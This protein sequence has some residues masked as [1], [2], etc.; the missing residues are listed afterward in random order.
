MSKKTIYYLIDTENVGDRWIKAAEKSGKRDRFVIFYTEN[1]SKLLE[2]AL[3]RHVHDPRFIWLESASGNNAL[4]YQ[5]IGVLSYLVARHPKAKYHIFS[6]DHDYQ[7]P[8]TFWKNKGIDICQDSFDTPGKAKKKPKKK[9]KKTA[10]ESK[11]APADYLVEIAKAIPVSDASGWYTLLTALLGQETGREQYM[12]FREDEK[13]Q[14]ALSRYLLKEE[15][16][17]RE[18]ATALVLEHAG[19]DA[20]LSGEICSMV[21]AHSRKNLQAVKQDLDKKLGQAQG[22]KYYRVLRPVLRTLKI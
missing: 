12:K 17:R 5:L 3:L 15:S 22:L 1:H 8:I 9:Q 21:Q 13:L 20:S 10:Q 4:D 7:K 19:L 11:T 16:S 14:K 6:N 18:Q 2:Q